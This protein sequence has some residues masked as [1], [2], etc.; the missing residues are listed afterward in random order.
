MNNDKQQQQHVKEIEARRLFY[1]FVGVL[2]IMR[3]ITIKKGGERERKRE[4][5]IFASLFH[6]YFT[7]RPRADVRMIPNRER[8]RDICIYVCVRHVENLILVE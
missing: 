7:R 6:N 4:R 3:S 5:D 2:V 1:F 8:E